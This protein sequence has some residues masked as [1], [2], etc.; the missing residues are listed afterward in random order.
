[1]GIHYSATKAAL[2]GFTRHAAAE[3]GP[4]GITVNAVAPG[5]IETP[6]VKTVS[7]AVNDEVVRE[8]PLRRLGQPREVADL[9]VFL[10][11]RE[12]DFVTG[13]VIDV[14]GGWLMT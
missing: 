10:T 14:A 13:Q 3:L 6:M 5:R 1:V 8:T 12:A 4:S 7:S 9:C 2:I 11:S